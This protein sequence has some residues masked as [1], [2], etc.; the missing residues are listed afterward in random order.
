MLLNGGVFHGAALSERLLELLAGWRGEPLSR[1][2]NPEPE[3]AVARGAVAYGLARRGRGLK[4]GGG[5]A[6]GYF[7]VVEGDRGRKQGVCLLPRGT[8]E[9]R[10]IR[11]IEPF[12]AVGLA[13]AVSSD[14]LHRRCIPSGR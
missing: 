11:L 14:V 7:L 4:I 8:E 10:E 5:S 1:L 3:L 2:D 13:G 12:L 6:R 9:G